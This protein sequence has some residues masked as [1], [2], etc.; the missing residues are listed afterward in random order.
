MT[1]SLNVM[2]AFINNLFIFL[3]NFMTIYY[4]QKGSHRRML[5]CTQ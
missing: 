3:N 1:D 5:K 4:L 2:A